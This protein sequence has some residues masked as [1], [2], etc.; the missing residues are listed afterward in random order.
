[1]AEALRAGGVYKVGGRWV[2]AEGRETDG[3]AKPRS[4]AEEKKAQKEAEE[5]R[6]AA[7]KAEAERLALLQKTGA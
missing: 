4:A 6:L 5:A 3:P 2:D 1:M 7:E